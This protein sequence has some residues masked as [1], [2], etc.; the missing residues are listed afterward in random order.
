LD[1]LAA[2]L[3]GLS[4]VDWMSTA[5]F[6]RRMRAEHL[7][8]ERAAQFQLALFVIG[9]LAATAF[10]L[11]GLQRFWPILPPGV[12][13]GLILLAAIAASVPQVTWAVLTLRG[14]FR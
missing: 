6:A 10:G 4:F 14:R 1:T 13:T 12:P 11:L 3:I 8:T 5:A 9:S 2:V 7:S